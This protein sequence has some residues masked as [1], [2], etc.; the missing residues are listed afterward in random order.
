MKNL[1]TYQN[2]LLWLIALLLINWL[3]ASFFTRI[4]LTADKRYTLSPATKELISEAR[5]P[6]IIDVFLEGA[7]PPEFRRLRNETRQLLEE[8]SA[9]NSNIKFNFNNPL[10]DGEDAQTVA[11]E[12]LKMGMEP[13]RLS[14]MENGRNTEAIIFPW[15]IANRGNKS[16]KIPLL[17]NQLGSSDEERVTNSV[18]HL[19]YA[20]ADALMRLL[21]PREKKIAVMRGNGELPD[22]QIADFI[23]RLQ[24]YYL[25]APFTLDS[26]AVNPQKT[27]EQLKEYD[28]IIEAKP[29]QPYS[30]EEKYILDQYTMNGG[31]SLWLT[32]NVVMETD[33]LLNPQGT[34]LAY[35]RDLNLGDFFFS[36][37]IRINPSLVNDIYSAPII[38]ATGSGN[39]TRYNPYPWFYSPLT[40]SPD[41]HPIV[42]NIEAVKFEY[43]NPI[44]TL[45]NEVQKTI[46]LSSSPRTK[47]E[48]APLPISLEM[49]SR[50]PDMAAYTSG[51]QPLAVLLEG[52]FTSVYK[53][54]VKPFG[55]ENPRD[56]SKSTQMLV[57]SD[58]DVIKNEVQQG[59]PL[60]LG[61]QRFT[62]NTYGNKEF[63]LNAVNYMLDD[64][65][66]MNIRS[67]EIR[68]AFLDA[69]KT[70]E[71][72]LQWQLINL[73]LPLLLLGIFGFV[74][75]FFRKK[76]YQR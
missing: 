1:K 3:A 23:R 72:R 5:E 32:E 21:K 25:L 9:Y 36:Y 31:K 8:F 60:E 40:V 51:E 38:L 2:L 63:L 61:F 41:S 48:G 70:A 47:V 44:D 53:N 59:Q 35:P 20:F 66:L 39:N 30:E 24:D 42:N 26:A 56:E 33:S 29:T 27:L 55:I 10:E 18:Q 58:G 50:E 57:I 15:A 54:R 64:T 67:K 19:E 16:V 76:R 14:V 11:Q 43:A 6:I 49:V 74:F 75:Q 52:N 46:L 17:K 22:V 12:F 34:A 28:L 68:L 71:E 65:G 13:A 73:A 37:G 45:K 7:F 4:D 62:G 69:E